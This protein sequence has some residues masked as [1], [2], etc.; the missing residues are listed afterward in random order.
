M[1]NIF[2]KV[3]IVEDEER[4]ANRLKQLLFEID[5]TVEVIAEME[6]VREVVAYDW[7]SSGVQLLFLDIHL[8]DGSSFEIFEEVEIDLPVIFT[9]AYDQYA[10]EAFQINSVDYLLK[11]ID[12]TKLR[13]AIE[14]WQK[15]YQNPEKILQPQLEKLMESLAGRKTYSQNLLVAQKHKLVPVAVSDFALFYIENG[16]VR[17]VTFDQQTYFPEQNMDELEAMLDSSLFYRANRQMI[18]NQ[19]SITGIESFFNSRL[20]VS[21]NPSIEEDILISKAKAREFK[22]WLKGE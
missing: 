10:L 16:V 13:H 1:S 18:L 17:G 9:T 21:T 11:P 19:K 15:W 14:K 4:A 8:A 2:M 5:P 6:T 12:S 3:A 20:L 7:A 22:N